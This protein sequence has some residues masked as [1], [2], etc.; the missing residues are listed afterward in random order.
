M[1]SSCVLRSAITF[2]RFGGASS[3]ESGVAGSSAL[4]FL[5]A[6]YLRSQ[7]LFERRFIECE[8]AKIDLVAAGN[9]R[10]K[11]VDLHLKLRLP[12]LPLC[13]PVL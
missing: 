1:L 7:R 5:V 2:S 12:D 9:M 3:G 13:A 10:E 11:I 4:Q 8:A 6:L